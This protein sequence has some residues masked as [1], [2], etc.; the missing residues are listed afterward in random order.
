MFVGLG[1][2]NLVGGV[3]RGRGGVGVVAQ[4]KTL[5]LFALGRGLE[6]VGNEQI[7]LSFLMSISFRCD[8]GHIRVEFNELVHWTG[9]GGGG[10]GQGAHTRALCSK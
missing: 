4:V 2:A 9:C 3:S 7:L 6:G 8:R 10:G 5:I 1:C